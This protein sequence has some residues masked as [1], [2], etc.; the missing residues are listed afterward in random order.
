MPKAEKNLAFRVLCYFEKW[1]NDL[2]DAADKGRA[3]RNKRSMMDKR[4][5]YRM[6]GLAQEASYD[7]IKEAYEK[8]MSKLK[9]AD[10]QDDPE[11]ARKKMEEVREAYRVLTGAPPSSDNKKNTGHGRKRDKFSDYRRKDTETGMQDR[12]SGNKKAFFEGPSI[13]NA[14][15]SRRKSR[16][17]SASTVITVITLALTVLIAFMGFKTQVRDQ[18]YDELFGYEPLPIDQEEAEKI[19]EVQDFIYQIDFYRWLDD[20]TVYDYLDKIDWYAGENSYGD[21]VG[22]G[23]YDLIEALEIGDEADFFYYVTGI[24]DFYFTYDDASCAEVL[25][26]W[27][28]APSF[29]EV[30]GCTD[31]LSGQVILSYDEYLNYLRQVDSEYREENI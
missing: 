31:T 21:T 3:L 29:S 20:S 15:G 7:K 23:V 14:A 1:Y 19:W 11:Y 17:G 6:L 9:S 26:S 30:A 8:K 5:Y 28:E 25:I 13:S 10:Y 4:Y 18:E 27:M 24:D 16:S 22:D 12:P 2:S